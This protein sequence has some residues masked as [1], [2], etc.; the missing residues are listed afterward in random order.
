MYRRDA[1][2]ATLNCTIALAVL[3]IAVAVTAYTYDVSVV[4]VI[5]TQVENDLELSNLSAAIIDSEY[6]TENGQFRLKSAADLYDKFI[7]IFQANMG[8]E[9]IGGNKHGPKSGSCFESVI[10]YVTVSSF[11][12]YNPDGD[13]IEVS[14]YNSDTGA[15]N[16][17]VMN[18]SGGNVVT[19]DG[20]VVETPTLYT[21]VEV[22]LALPGTVPGEAE[23]GIQKIVT[24]ENSVAIVID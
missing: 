4:S 9:H 16:I 10:S 13:N 6:Y 21:K 22:K 11:I 18:N 17:Q 3:I 23:I 8:L 1:G 15:T 12:V 14:E 24:R 7:D 19:P 2:S 20:A 5:K